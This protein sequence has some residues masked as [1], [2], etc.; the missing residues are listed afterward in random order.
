MRRGPSLSQYD[1]SDSASV[2]AG[3]WVIVTG[4]APL[5]QN[6]VTATPVQ[7]VEG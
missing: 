5:G 2:R 3:D 4:A 1:A 7:R 6:R